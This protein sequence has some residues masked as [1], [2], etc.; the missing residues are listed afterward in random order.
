MSRKIKGTLP[1]ILGFLLSPVLYSSAHATGVRIVPSV[2]RVMPGESFYFDV[3]ADNVPAGG[4]SAFNIK[5]DVSSSGANIASVSDLSQAKAGEISVVSPLLTG[6]VTSTRS[7]LG[8]F[9]LNGEGPNGILSVDNQSFSAGSAVFTFGHT[10]G[11]T[12]VSG[13]GSIARFQMKVGEN[14]A[15]GSVNLG[16]PEAFFFVNGSEHTLDSVAGSVVEIG[17]TVTVPNLAGLTQAEAQNQ[18][19]SSSLTMGNVY[20]IDN[21]SGAYQLG[22]VLAQSLGSGSQ[23]SCDSAINIAVNYSPSDV[24]QALASDKQND[25]TGTVVISWLPSQ[26]ADT[27]GY[28]IFFGGTLLKEVSTPGA[29]GAEATGLLSGQTSQ[30]KIAS[31]DVFGN[32]S[33]GIFLSVLPQDDVAPVISIN[34]VQ[35]GAFYNSDIIPSVAVSDANMAAQSMTL[36]GAP[37]YGDAITAEGSYV[38]GSNASDTAGN[39]SS[40]SVSFIIDKTPPA[41]SIT[42]VQNGGF[43]NADISPVITVDDQNISSYSST[44]NG[45]AYTGSVLSSEGIYEL[46]TDASDR[47][48]NTASTIYGFYID[49]T[50]PQSGLALGAPVF[51]DSGTTYLSAATPVSLTGTDT[52]VAPSGVDRLEYRVNSGAWALYSAPFTLT[53]QPDGAYTV[54]YRAYDKA[55]N[56]GNINTDSF[57]ADNT[58][59]SAQIAVGAPAYQGMNGKQ[60]A[61]AGSLISLSASDASS[62]VKSI[63]YRIGSG[64]WA[65]YSIPFTLVVEGENLINYRSSDNLDNVEAEKSKAV[66]LD[67]TPPATSLTLSGPEY[68][69]GTNRYISSSTIINFSAVD[70]LS[71]AALTE[72]RVGAGAYAPSAPFSISSEGTHQVVFRSRDNVGN[73]ETEKTQVLIADN[74]PPVTQITVGEPSFTGQDGTIHADTTAQ[75]V[76]SASDGLSGVNVTEYRVDGGNWQPYSQFQLS[77]GVHAVEY[78]S[79]DHLGN[80]EAA[81]TLQVYSENA[82]DISKSALDYSRVLVWLN[83][84]IVQDNGTGNCFDEQVVQNALNDAGV[85]YSIVKSKAAFQSELLSNYYTDYLILGDREVIDDLQAKELRERVN[86]GSGLVASLLGNG[87]LNEAF[88]ADSISS[89]IDTNLAASFGQSDIYQQ[90]QYQTSGKAVNASVSGSEVLAWMGAG[91]AYPGVIRKAYGRGKAIFFAFDLG[92]TLSGNYSQFTGILGSSL[93]HVHRPADAQPAYMPYDLVPLRISATNNWD[94]FDLKLDESYPVSIKLIDGATGQWIIDNPWS[95][96]IHLVSNETKNMNLFALTP[97][98]QGVSTLSAS[99][100][101]LDAELWKH[102]S[103]VSI[104]LDVVKSAG[105][106]VNDIISGLDGLTV[107]GA[108]LTERDSARQNIIAVRDRAVYGTAE[109]DLNI[110]DITAAAES[111]KKIVSIDTSALRLEIDSLLRVWSERRYLGN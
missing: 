91:N 58:P 62:G 49:K 9:F 75:L 111:V 81:N 30:I 101:Y 45:V 69:F 35:D 90:A 33:S 92:Y 105:S 32:Q 97:D 68:I 64:A 88:G 18:I 31:F 84:C 78:R 51:Q 53:G 43:Y 15:V 93:N 17:C 95:I 44:L 56:I 96:T 87:F 48:G 76:L 20:E 55:G 73:L 34:G 110:Q 1:L 8:D 29:T 103:D 89:L 50:S 102:Y 71:G 10:N 25:E 42:G 37:Y 106:L 79:S 36:N 72:Y 77:S 26:S 60:Y 14:A 70:S 65:G 66:T 21:W 109:M 6:P 5:L 40:K 39:S 46:R 107:T 54:D 22:A 63:E 94:V 57:M 13:S 2:S 85:S 23:V 104:D 28:R 41:V 98:A 11:F 83:A 4:L 80:V 47:A 74:T 86:F 24:T 19:Q 38:L 52:G 67:L 59:S 3:V 99:V 16:L 27:A 7:G 82:V 61:G 108:E 100:D 12:P